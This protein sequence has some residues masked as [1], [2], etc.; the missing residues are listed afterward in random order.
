MVVPW[1]VFGFSLLGPL[2]GVLPPG[3]NFLGTFSTICMRAQLIVGPQSKWLGWVMGVVRRSLQHIFG[4]ALKRPFQ[5]Y[6][7]P[8]GM[9]GVWASQPAS[10]VGIP[11]EK[12]CKSK[13]IAQLWGFG[14]RYTPSYQFIWIAGKKT[15]QMVYICL[16][17]KQFLRYLWCIDINTQ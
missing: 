1:D 11:M 4:F 15:F 7:G 16:G 2:L 13:Y 17:I 10:K 3:S 14:G 8:W 12:W 5:R 6:M 9:V